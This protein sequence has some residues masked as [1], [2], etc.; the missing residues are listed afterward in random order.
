[1]MLSAQG[2]AELDWLNI[3]MPDVSNVLV[4]GVF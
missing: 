2:T 1:M 3:W 4:I